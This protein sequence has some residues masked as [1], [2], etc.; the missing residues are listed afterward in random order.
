MRKKIVAG[1]W[2]MNLTKATASALFIE[3]I[4]KISNEIS[5]R[6]SIVLCPASIHLSALKELARLPSLVG[7]GAQ[8]CSDKAAG[9]YTGEV[10]A[11]MLAS[12]GVTYV[13]LGHSERR[14]Y[15]KETHQMLT[16]KV[17]M[18]IANKLSPIFCCGETVEQRTANIAGDVVRRQLKESLFHLPAEDFSKVILAYEPVW[19]IGTGM[20]ATSQQAQ[21]MHEFMRKI[22][23][24]KYGKKMANS[25]VIL[26]G[27]SCK[28]ANAAALFACPDVDGGLIG[29]ASLNADDFINI[30]KSF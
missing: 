7:L 13:I 22:V 27:G 19:A 29:G 8:N 25:T 14:A 2:K 11:S 30:I 15:F 24:E 18:A 17:N 4:S 23:A 10:S 21:D 3:I 1:N 28:P 9:A 12:Y 16:D 26:Y 5:A 20:T 6:V